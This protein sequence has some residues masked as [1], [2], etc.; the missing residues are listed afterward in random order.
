ME[1]AQIAL[2]DESH[3]IGVTELI[4]NISAKN[5]EKHENIGMNINSTW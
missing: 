1:T 4:K 2:K 5:R 3:L